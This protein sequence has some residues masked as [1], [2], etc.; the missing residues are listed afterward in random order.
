MQGALGRPADWS[1]GRTV[2]R[3]LTEIESSQ[4]KADQLKRTIDEIERR[5]GLAEDDVRDELRRAGTCDSNDVAF[6]FTAK[7]AL[8]RRDN[9]KS[10]LAFLQQ[11]LRE[12]GSALPFDALYA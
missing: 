11:K 1:A 8:L 6:P 10:T 12:A 4:R 5:L 3:E 2:R 7:A 9:L